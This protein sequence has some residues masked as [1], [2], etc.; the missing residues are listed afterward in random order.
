MRKEEPFK[1][2]EPPK[3]VQDPHPPSVTTNNSPEPLDPPIAAAKVHIEQGGTRSSPLP[4]APQSNP[5]TLLASSMQ[6]CREPPLDSAAA[7]TDSHAGTH[8]EHVLP[9]NPRISGTPAPAITT[10]A[11]LFNMLNGM[12]ALTDMCLLDSSTHSPASQPD[13]PPHHAPPRGVLQRALSLEEVYADVQ[14]GCVECAGG[15]FEPVETWDDE[16]TDFEMMPEEGFADL[17]YDAEDAPVC[18]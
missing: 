10:A 5:E 13:V 9:T 18:P 16:V 7:C 3:Q 1:Q 2:E 15:T 11:D 14:D 4:A 6:A 12:A 17:T 8:P